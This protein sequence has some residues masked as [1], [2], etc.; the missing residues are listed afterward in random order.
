MKQI[1]TFV[2]DITKESTG[3]SAVLLEEDL[4]NVVSVGESIENSLGYDNFVKKLVDKIG[5]V[6]FVDRIYYKDELGLLKDS[7]EYGSIL[8][9]IQCEIPEATE[10]PTWQLNDKQ[11]YEENLLTLPKVSV[12]FF[13]NDK[14]FEIPYSITDEQVRSA[15]TDPIQLGSFIS[16]IETSVYNSMEIKVEQLEHRAITNMIGE[17]L[18]KD[19]MN[20]DSNAS[21]KSAVRSVNLLYLYK[22]TPQGAD[23]NL[24][25]D[26]CIYDL[27]FLRFATGYIN[28]YMARLTKATRLFNIGNKLRFTPKSDLHVILHSEFVHN[29][30]TYLQ[31][32]TFHNEFVKLPYAREIAFWQGVGDDF[33]L[34][35]T[36]AIN[37]KTASNSTAVNNKGIL[38]VMFDNN[39]LGINREFR[40]TTA[41]RNDHAEFVNYWAK[42]RARW[43]NDLNENFV[44]FLVA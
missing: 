30:Y 6:V 38:G 1:A 22:K 4:S 13:N 26:N 42:F 3:D 33:E 25:A 31:S 7:W 24:T 9:K 19:G 41:K 11:V 21:S 18:V 12:E 15:F 14:T 34:D 43:Y 10:N 16:M 44:V 28:K 2:N 27:E 39:C 23:T 36:T 8:Q 35:T 29:S 5:R 20:S 32:D 40:K 37:I 17:T